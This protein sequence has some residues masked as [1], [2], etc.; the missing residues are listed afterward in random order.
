M[1]LHQSSASYRLSGDG[2]ARHLNSEQ[3]LSAGLASLIDLPLLTTETAT[4]PPHCHGRVIQQQHRWFMDIIETNL[5][6]CLSSVYF[7]LS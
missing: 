7:K 2:E 1:M 6:S 4:V 3:S 5:L